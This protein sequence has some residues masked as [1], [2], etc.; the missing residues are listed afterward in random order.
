MSLDLNL[1]TKLY[2]VKCIPWQRCLDCRYNETGR[3]L[4]VIS[5]ASFYHS[6]NVTN[7]KFPAHQDKTKRVNEM[8]TPFKKR[9][10]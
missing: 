7:S 2:T 1:K 5:P 8:F 4:K 9:V 3:L 6:R 10:N